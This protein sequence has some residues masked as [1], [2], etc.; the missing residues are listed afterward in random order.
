MKTFIKLIIVLVILYGFFLAEE[1]IRIKY[2]RQ[3]P[4]YIIK[5]SGECDS[6]EVEHTEKSYQTSCKGLGYRIDREYLLGGE[7]DDE[8][9]GYVLVKEEFWIFDKFM[10]WGWIS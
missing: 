8:S 1:S 7:V 2:S 3:D 10:L 4:I 5:S 9:K 6:E